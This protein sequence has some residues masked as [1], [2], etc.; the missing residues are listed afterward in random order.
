MNLM[1]TINK[2]RL[3]VVD[4][5][6]GVIAAYRLVLERSPKRE[7]LEHMFGLEALETELFGE[8]AANDLH[9]RVTFLDQG[10]DAVKAVQWAADDGDP[11]TAIFLDVRM[12]PGIDGYEAAEQIR[13]IDD[14]VHIVIVTGYSDY[15]YA[16]F[17]EVAGPESK[18]TYM[19]K[20]VW[21]DELRK[22]A[23]I[24]SNEPNYRRYLSPLGVVSDA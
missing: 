14:G 15:T 16:D 9:W 6:L 2:P 21:P 23:S 24:L 22:V 1:T 11:Y 13:K 12:P 3:L 18:L 8:H 5:D 20:P 19:P 7:T 17:L 4:D 10:A